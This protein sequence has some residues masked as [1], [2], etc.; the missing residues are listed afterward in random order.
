M[1]PFMSDTMNFK[2]THLVN[3]ILYEIQSIDVKLWRF[4]YIKRSK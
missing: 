2:A 1:V 4:F 3:N